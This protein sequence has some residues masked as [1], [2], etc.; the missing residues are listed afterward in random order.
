MHR[1]IKRQDWDCQLLGDGFAFECELKDLL[2]EPPPF[3]PLRWLDEPELLALQPQR[4]HDGRERGN[5]TRSKFWHPR[6]EIIVGEGAGRRKSGRNVSDKKGM[7]HLE[8]H[9]V[10]GR[11]IFTLEEC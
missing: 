4:F 10:G 11:V 7:S 8:N 6:C 3:I 2:P 9:I 1:P 5:C